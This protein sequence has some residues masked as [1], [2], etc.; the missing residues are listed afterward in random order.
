MLVDC[1]DPA[2]G[3]L[4]I[5]RQSFSLSHVG[6][7]HII[8]VNDGGRD[9]ELGGFSDHTKRL[10]LIKHVGGQDEV[11]R[12][13]HLKKFLIETNKVDEIFR[14]S[15]LLYAVDT[16]LCPSSSEAIQADFLIPSRDNASI[17]QL[18]WASIT[19][20][21][22]NR[23]GY[24]S[25]CLIFLQLYY[26][27]VISHGINVVDKFAVPVIAWGK[28]EV[29]KLIGWIK[30]NGGFGSMA[31]HASKDFSH[32]SDGVDHSDNAVCWKNQIVAEI[33]FV[34]EDICTL[35]QE[36]PLSF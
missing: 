10:Q 14:I 16:I 21:Q 34:K 32:K 4:K 18:N 2:S 27:D 17:C 24:M 36:L 11:L 20:F 1:F 5:H 23:C 30:E 3:S 15:F 7:E 8:G 25:E 6:F 28:R 19:V 35:L 26:F 31:I 12:R 22:K 33:T 13:E 9:I 29:N